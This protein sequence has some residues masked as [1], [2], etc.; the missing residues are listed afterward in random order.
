MAPLTVLIYL[1]FNAQCGFDVM[2][3]RLLVT[4]FGGFVA[5]SVVWQAAH[6]G[7]WD[8]LAV[9]HREP[10]HVPKGVTCVQADLC[11]HARLRDIVH[12]VHPDAVIHAAAKADIDYCQRH[13]AE[14]ESINAG[15]PGEL[16]RLCAETGAKLV[17][18]STD[19]VFDGKKGMY[20]ETD[21]PHPLNAYAEAK[22]RAEEAVLNLA[23]NAVVARLSLV[24][25]LPVLG[26]G[27]SFLARMLDDLEHD[28]PGKFLTNE[29]RTPLDVITAGRAL[30]ELADNDFTGIIHLAG[31]TRGS[32]YDM[33]C[34]I[35][36]H[37]G[38][39]DSLI[40]PI[41]LGA[42]LGRAPRPPDASLD[43]ALAKTTLT[44]PMQTLLGGLDLVLRGT[45]EQQGQ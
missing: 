8:V 40:H 41:N 18:C 37:L 34:Q 26:A 20:V 15:V 22:V 27:N 16:A 6:S 42:M 29:V 4:G 28:R 39:A 3:K 44:T 33:A 11:D 9:S 23:P 25:G 14:A 10:I 19:T 30:L 12:S 45:E 17:H 32:R 7:A 2:Q 31:S 24:M 35:A 36:R 38:Y 43:N 1:A 21:A 13:P 5:G